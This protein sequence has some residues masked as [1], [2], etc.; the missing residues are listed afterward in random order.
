MVLRKMVKLS[1]ALKSYGLLSHSCDILRLTTKYSMES[2]KKGAKGDNVR[3]LQELLHSGGYSLSRS[4]KDGIDGVFG[5]DTKNAVIYF[6]ALNDIS[7]TDGVATAEVQSKLLSGNFL[8]PDSAKFP[9]DPKNEKIEYTEKDIDNLTRMIWVETAFDATYNEISQTIWAA[10]NRS[11]LWKV[12]LHKVVDPDRWKRG[13]SWFGRISENNRVR[14]DDA[15]DSPKWNYMRKFIKNQLD[16]ISFENRIGNRTGF[17]HT[18][19]MPGCNSEPGSPCGSKNHRIC[20][21]TKWGKRCLPK[22]TV[23]GEKI[24][25]RDVAVL[26]IDNARFS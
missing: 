10:I 22:W 11:K 12:P 21:E 24:G 17:L 16:G 23:E 13:Q 20:V 1:E 6:Q 18:P 3:K 5:N 26:E 14:W 25:N 2:L 8:N 7:P 9:S 4:S 19:F 15:D